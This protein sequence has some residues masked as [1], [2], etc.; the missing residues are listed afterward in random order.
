MKSEGVWIRWV[1]DFADGHAGDCELTVE[2][3]ARV[4]VQ[5]G[6]AVRLAEPPSGSRGKAYV[7]AKDRRGRIGQWPD[8]D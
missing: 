6:L 5:E 8:Q 7:A 1:K 2:E 3:L 4:Y